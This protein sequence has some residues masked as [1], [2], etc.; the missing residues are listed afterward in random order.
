MVSLPSGFI[1]GSKAS[2]TSCFGVACGLGLDGDAKRLAVNDF[3]CLSFFSKLAPVN[4]SS[5]F[6]AERRS[7]DRLCNRFE[8]SKERL[9]DASLVLFCIGRATFDITLFSVLLTPVPSCRFG[10]ETR[11]LVSAAVECSCSG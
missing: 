10:L 3:V 7:A 6:V 8:I 4:Q 5:P 1:R 2:R 11:I 9:I